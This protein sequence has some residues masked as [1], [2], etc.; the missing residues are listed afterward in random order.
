[1]PAILDMSRKGILSCI[2]G[3]FGKPRLLSASK[4]GSNPKASTLAAIR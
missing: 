1:M 2:G 3:S 4:M